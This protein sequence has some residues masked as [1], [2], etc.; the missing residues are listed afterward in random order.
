MPK[1]I[2]VD[3]QD[4]TTAVA[5]K[6]ENRRHYH[7]RRIHGDGRWVL[8]STESII[9]ANRLHGGAAHH[10]AECLRSCS[11]KVQVWGRSLNE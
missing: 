4:V 5:F 10:I 11:D 8:V 1:Q 2:T 9:C 7:L 3:V 6:K